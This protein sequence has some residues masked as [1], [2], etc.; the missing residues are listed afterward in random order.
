MIFYPSFSLYNA[1]V[2]KKG[3][4]LC[5]AMLHMHTFEYVEHT[6]VVDAPTDFKRPLILSNLYHPITLGCHGGLEVER[7]LYQLHDSTSA[8]V[9]PLGTH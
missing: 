5:G 4:C 1:G 9:P 3:Q 6:W 8:E 2:V 7:L